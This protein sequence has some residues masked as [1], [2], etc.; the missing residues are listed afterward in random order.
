MNGLRVRLTFTFT[1]FRTMAPIMIT[2]SG[3][4]E[5]ELPGT[6][7]AFVEIQ[8]LCIALPKVSKNVYKRS[9][10]KD[11]QYWEAV[12]VPAPLQK[13]KS[14]QQWEMYP[15]DFKEEWVDYIESQFVFRDEGYWFKNNGK[16][17]YIT[18]T[19]W[20]YLTHSKTDVGHPDYRESN[21]IFFIFQE[22]APKNVS[23]L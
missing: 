5:H 22:V 16:D 15:D 23:I 18:G 14:T 10:S 7:F 13:I 6:D 3:L 17:T 11:E 1:A 2:V 20:M 19:H 12:E 9:G 21:R 8:G 4:D